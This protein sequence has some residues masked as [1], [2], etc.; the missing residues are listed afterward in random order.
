[1]THLGVPVPIAWDL[2]HGILTS[3]PKVE[4]LISVLRTVR[5]KVQVQWQKEKNHWTGNRK[6]SGSKSA[7]N[8]L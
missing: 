1:M 3:V 8:L 6:N 2:S 4:F 5:G 7:I